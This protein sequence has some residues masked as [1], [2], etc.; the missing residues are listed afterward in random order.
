LG[1]GDLLLA[2]AGAKHTITNRSDKPAK[3]LAIY[4]TANPERVFV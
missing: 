3:V 2:P 1:P 4:P